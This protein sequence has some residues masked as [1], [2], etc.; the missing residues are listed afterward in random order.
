MLEDIAQLESPAKQE[1]R[2]INMYVTP[3]KK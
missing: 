2:Y 1:G 3:L